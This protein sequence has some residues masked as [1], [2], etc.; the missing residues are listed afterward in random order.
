MKQ[1]VLNENAAAHIG[2]TCVC[3][4]I[5]CLIMSGSGCRF[6]F[7]G[8][9]LTLNTGCDADALNDGKVC[10]FPRIAVFVDG[11]PVVKK[12]LTGRR[13][14]FAVISSDTVTRSMV[15]IVKL[16]EAA[17]SIAEIYAAESDDDASFE[18]VQ[19]DSALKIEFI[20]DSITCG[21]G[22]DDVT[23][24]SPFSTGAENALK[25]Y[26]CLTAAALDAEYSIFAASGYGVISGYTSDGQ[27]NGADI[28]PPHYGSLGFSYSRLPNGSAP[29]DMQWEFSR[30]APDIVV[31][32]LGTNDE[33]FCK[34]NRDTESEFA[35]E[36]RRFISRVREMNPQAAIICCLGVIKTE[37]IRQVRAV[38]SELTDENDW[39]RLYFVEFPEQNG[40]LG[41]AADWHPSE[42][43]HAL[44]A[45]QL[46]EFIN[47]NILE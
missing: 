23:V 2:R 18:P 43:T 34:V 13:E 6:M 41:Y 32:N 3:G 45:E 36:Y 20:G 35:A 10:N 28:I 8:R 9:C 37:L 24:D 21:Y 47:S 1:T 33:N 11:K 26:A 14:S 4:D 39:K 30:F 12:V 19:R 15:E 38:C 29:H 22:I 27:W 44:M 5:L 16:S 25:S 17:F 7:E 40:L 46:V 42:D 31:V